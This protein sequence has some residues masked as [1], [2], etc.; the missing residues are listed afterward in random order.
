M[1]RRTL[2]TG[3]L[4]L[5]ATRGLAASGPFEITRSPAEWRALLTPAEFAVMREEATE[6]P[7][8]SPLNTETRAGTYHC[9][10]CDLPVYDAGHK[11]DSGTGWPSFWQSLP[12]AVRTKPDNTLFATRTEVHCRRCGSHFGHIFNDGPQPTGKRH[13]LNG[14]SLTFRV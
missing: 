4:A 1:H 13:C 2:L 14:I 8:S 10:G 11:Y 7:Y 5:A 3:A 6:K 9:K 12:E